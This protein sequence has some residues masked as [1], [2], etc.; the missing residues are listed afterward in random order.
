MIFL[1][2]NLM[3]LLHSLKFSQ[4]EHFSFLAYLPHLRGGDKVDFQSFCRQSLSLSSYSYHQRS[5]DFFQD[6]TMLPEEEALPHLLL[7]WFIIG[8]KVTGL[9]MQLKVL[10]QFMRICVTFPC[11]WFS[12]TVD[13]WSAISTDQQQAL[14]VIQKDYSIQFQFLPTL[15]PS[16]FALFR[17]TSNYRV[18][19]KI[20]QDTHS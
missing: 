10:D 1:I 13:A 9:M 7:L 16:I 15:H 19:R 12:P 3:R 11:L 2:Q 20:H 17:D 18:L 8:T 6:K 14:E 4:K 5:P